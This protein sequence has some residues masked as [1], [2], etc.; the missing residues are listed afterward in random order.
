MSFLDTA[1]G[2]VLP[3]A[4]KRQAQAVRVLFTSSH[5]Y[6]A[7]IAGFDYP[8]EPGYDGG[9]SVT[10]DGRFSIPTVQLT[11][12]DGEVCGLAAIKALRQALQDAEKMAERMS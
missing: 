6:D 3:P 10:F 7:G 5:S 11:P 1:A 9:F 12:A 4:A 2:I 8:T